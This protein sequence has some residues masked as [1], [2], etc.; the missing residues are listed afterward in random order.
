MRRFEPYVNVRKDMGPASMPIIEVLQNDAVFVVNAALGKY[1][2]LR[3][4]YR[5]IKRDRLVGII[6]ID[7]WQR[8]RVVH[9]NVDSF[10]VRQYLSTFTGKFNSNLNLFKSHVDT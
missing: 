6:S 7:C 1:F 3:V 4:R 5:F 2:Y 10:I 9:A 8:L